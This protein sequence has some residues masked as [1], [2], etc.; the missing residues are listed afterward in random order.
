MTQR[1]FGDL[2]RDA[3]ADTSVS[4]LAQALNIDRGLIYRWLRNERVPRLNTPYLTGIARYLRLDQTTISR[5]RQAQIAAL[6]EQS[7]L[8]KRKRATQAKAG[9]AVTR[10]LEHTQ[11]RPLAL[12][13]EHVPVEAAPAIV[14]LQRSVL[15]GIGEIMQAIITLLN[16]IPAPKNCRESTILISVQGETA[17][18]GESPAADLGP[19]WQQALRSLV[20]RGWEI[21]QLWRLDRDVSRSLRVVER[22]AGLIGSSRYHPR[23]FKRYGILKPPYDIVVVPGVAAMLMFAVETPQR[24]D[25]AILLTQPEQ[26]DQIAAH[27]HQLR[28]QTRPLL[29]AF[30]PPAQELTFTRALAEAESGPGGR[31][32][33]ATGPSA[34]TLPTSWL[35]RDSLWAKYAIERGFVSENDLP[36]Y[37]SL[38]KGRV[39]AFDRFA[40]DHDYREIY[41]QRTI[42][43]LTN[44]GRYDPNMPQGDDEWPVAY[45]IEHLEN[46]MRMLRIYD[47]YQI[48]LVDAD[49]ERMT[50]CEPVLGVSGRRSFCSTWSYDASGK[51]VLADLE[52]TER[53]IVEAVR[54]HIDMLWERVSPEHRDKTYVTSFLQR[55]VTALK[56]RL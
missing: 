21:E 12:T 18:K 4:A 31:L 39:D 50:P 3:L 10:F 32:M 56:Q 52:I 41:P 22:V 37:A 54:D 26:I 2:L 14:P 28:A 8:A 49:E 40:H 11:T 53:T 19:A 20:E 23:Y 35:R 29:R 55:Q 24:V 15:R 9:T 43:D 51:V 30:V 44:H 42:E 38:L 13:G 1:L 45:R 7:T 6:S 48:A 5:L 33:I 36:E 34:V 27:F 47:G 17:F 16:G 25:R 46:I